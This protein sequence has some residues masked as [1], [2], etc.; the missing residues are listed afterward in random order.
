MRNK[1]F[2]AGIRGLIDKGQFDALAQRIVDDRA[3]LAKGFKDNP[4]VLAVVDNCI[5]RLQKVWFNELEAIDGV[6]TK[7]ELSKK[8]EDK[9]L[10]LALKHG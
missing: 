6:I 9:I 5:L 4:E 2:H 10:K 7:K 3:H 1:A 8:A